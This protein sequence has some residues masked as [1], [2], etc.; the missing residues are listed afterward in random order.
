[1]ALKKTNKQFLSELESINNSIIPLQEYK[2]AITPIKCKC[3]IC[4]FEWMGIPNNLLRKEGCPACAGHIKGTTESFKKQMESINPDLLITGEYINNKTPISYRCKI[5][6]KDNIAVPSSLKNGH[7]CKY[8]ARIRNVNSIRHTNDWFISKLK[9]NNPEIIPLECYTTLNKKIKYRC[10]CGRIGESTPSSLL[11]GRKCKDCEKETKSMPLKWTTESFQR[12]LEMINPNIK[13]LGKYEGINAKISCKCLLCNNEW[14]KE[15]RQLLL[16]RGCPTCQKRLHTSF[17]EQAFYFYLRAVFPDVINSY[18]EGFVHSEIDIFIPSKSVGIEYDGEIWHK[19]KYESEKSKYDTC[20]DKGI[21]LIRIRE[22]AD[23]IVL[24]KIC[25]YYILSE[26]GKEKSF[27][28]LDRCIGQ[29]FDYLQIK[30]DFIDT[31]KDKNAIRSLY[32][33]RL[34]NGSL[35]VVAPDIAKE[36]YQPKNGS[37]L[38]SM[39]TTGTTDRYYWQCPQCGYIYIT[40]VH[41][42]VVG[43]GCARCAGVLNKSHSDFVDEIEGI[44]PDIEILSEYRNANTKVEIR[45]KKCGAFHSISPRVLLNGGGCGFCNRRKSTSKRMIPNDVFKYKAEKQSPNIRILGEFKGVKKRVRC[46]CK[47][48]GRIWE[49]IAESLLAGNTGCSYCAGNKKRKVLCIDTGEIF[50]SIGQAEK[51][52]KISHSTIINCCKGK[53][54]TAGG[55]R[56]QYVD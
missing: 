29:L 15:P 47:T 53:G 25:D 38:P 48:C 52:K 26:Y 31:E 33:S 12:E 39:V 3:K 19:N 36:W 44:N 40:S 46:E 30:Y 21:F 34:K 20:K 4:G 10:S 35:E 1:M 42:R 37:I 24:D 7:G 27:K 13:V 41:S 32:Y 16:G 49:P 5:C 2:N 11:K 14:V 45:C 17:A 18:K 55:F 9:E 28:S 50:E 56:W 51:Q 54:K 6:G 23:D 43:H 8:C 22:N